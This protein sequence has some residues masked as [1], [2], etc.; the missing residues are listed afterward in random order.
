M[1]IRDRDNTKGDIT[2]LYDDTVY[3]IMIWSNPIDYNSIVENYKKLNNLYIYN[4]KIMHL[5]KND[6]YR[7]KIRLLFDDGG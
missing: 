2:I 1:C 4:N 7:T 6:L 3:D 5:I